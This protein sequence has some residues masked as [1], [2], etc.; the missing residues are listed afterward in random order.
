MSKKAKVAPATVTRVATGWD[1]TFLICRKCNKKLS[2]GFGEDGD[3]PLKAA[4]RT[5]LRETGR[6]GRTAIIE[7]D[8]FGVCPKKGV[9]VARSSQPGSLLV[10][11]A[12]TN[13]SILLDCD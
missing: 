6:R 13:P 9:V 2:G 4:L 10:V 1:E 8:C 3:E 11:G 5:R 7:V 12:G